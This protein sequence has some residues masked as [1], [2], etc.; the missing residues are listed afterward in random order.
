MGKVKINLNKYNKALSLES[1]N[2][3]E[4]ILNANEYSM[5][6]LFNKKMSAEKYKEI[7]P[8]IKEC[9]GKLY[10]M[11]VAEAKHG[12]GALL[13]KLQN[14]FKDVEKIKNVFIYS[15]KQKFIALLDAIISG[16]NKE[17]K[18]APVVTVSNMGTLRQ[19]M[20]KGSNKFTTILNKLFETLEGEIGRVMNVMWYNMVMDHASMKSLFGQIDKDTRKSTKLLNLVVRREKGNWFEKIFAA[21]YAYYSDRTAL[22]FGIEPKIRLKKS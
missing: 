7:Q 13:R 8:K 20:E 16:E 17:T 19:E 21:D 9:A 6:A 3:R 12:E 10:D 22:F 11:I 1:V 4:Y 2:P 18:F 14:Q 15:D 5:E